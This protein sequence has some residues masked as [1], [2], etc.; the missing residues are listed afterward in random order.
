[1]RGHPAVLELE[2]MEPAQGGGI[3]VLPA[4]GQPGLDRLERKGFL[5]QLQGR[6]ADAPGRV[7]RGHQCHVERAGASQAGSGRGVAAGAQVGGS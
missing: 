4:P 5:G 7:E 3:L 2:A 1:M 6:P